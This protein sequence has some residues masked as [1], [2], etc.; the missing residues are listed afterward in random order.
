MSDDVLNF[1]VSFFVDQ[2]SIFGFIH[3]CICNGVRE[4]L[5]Q[6]GR[7]TQHFVLITTIES[8]D[9]SDTRRGASERTGLIE[10]DRI[11]S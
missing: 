6:A 5:F 1:C 9:L 7:Q 10:Y 8:N 11:C 3:D 4:V 2:S